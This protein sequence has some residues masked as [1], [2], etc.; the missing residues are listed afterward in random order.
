MIKESS[1]EF[2]GVKINYSLY[3][4]DVIDNGRKY[5]LIIFLHGAGERGDDITKV[6]KLGL[7]K[8]LKDGMK[9]EAFVLSPQ[10]PSRIVWANITFD[11]KTL[12]DS[13]IN[14]YPVD[15]SKVALTGASM[16]GYGTWD[17]GM[18]YSNFF[19]CILPICGEGSIWRVI[20][21]KNMPVYA[22]HGANDSLIP[23]TCSQKIVD[24]VN[25]AGG[26]A[27]LTILPNKGHN[28]H[29]AVYLESGGIEW[30]LSQ[31]RTDFSIQKEAFDE[32]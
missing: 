17:I 23:P 28:C 29:D 14:C 18:T 32:L 8:Y 12:I 26:S 21:L 9:M 3:L 7:P 24:A 2:R 22:Y 19:S 6:Y 30:M 16:G 11:I 20:N 13:I 25:G 5:P 4:P 1:S 27:K 10:C 15:K 31:K